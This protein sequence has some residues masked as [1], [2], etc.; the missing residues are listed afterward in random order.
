MS[1][2]SSVLVCPGCH[3]PTDPHSNQ[4]DHC[5]YLHLGRLVPGPPPAP[6]P[7]PPSPAFEQTPADDTAGPGWYADPQGGPE[8]RY[9]DGQ[10]WLGLG[11]AGQAPENDGLAT[12]GWI[13]AILMPLI[14]LIVGIVLS[15]RND[16]RGTQ[17]AI[18][19]VAAFVFWIIIWVVLAVA[20]SPSYGY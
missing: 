19:A 6:A 2:T 13:T 10:R 3:Q 18:A 5:R 16:R 12:I 15:S 7:P 8:Q 9:W 20:S 1:T 17:I 11:T 4:C 14:G